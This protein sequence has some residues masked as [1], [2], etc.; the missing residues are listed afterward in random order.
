MT[1]LSEYERAETNSCKL[2]QNVIKIKTI[3]IQSILDDTNL[4]TLVGMHPHFLIIT[5]A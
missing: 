4:L 1:L 5:H 2:V 3:C